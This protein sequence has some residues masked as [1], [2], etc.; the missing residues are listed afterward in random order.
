M[1]AAHIAFIFVSHLLALATAVYSAQTSG[2]RVE[3]LLYAFAIDYVF[4]LGAIKALHDELTRPDKSWFGVIAPYVVRKPARGQEFLP[5]QEG[6]NGPP[7]RLGVY[8]LV[9]AVMGL[10]LFLLANVGPDQKLHVTPGHAMEDLSWALLIA[11]V[12]FVNSLL[13]RA[14]V[15]DPAQSLKVNLGYNTR[16]V[17]VLALSVLAAGVVVMYR[18]N[19]DLPQSAWVVMGPLLGFKFLYDLWASLDAVSTEDDEEHTGE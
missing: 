3:V 12:Y 18:Q 8:F 13:T 16:E 11:A 5:V 15:I 7:A 10:F 19:N 4:R 6:E 9:M 1:H 14:V 17:T 2:V